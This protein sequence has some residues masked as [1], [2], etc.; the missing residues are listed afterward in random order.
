MYL[1]YLD[2]SGDTSNYQEQAHFVIA[3]VGIYEFR[4]D[5]LAKR[6]RETQR[7]YFPQINIP[8]VFHATD[9][10][11]GKG[12]FRTLTK[13]T[14]EKLLVD[15]YNII[16]EHRFPNVVVFGAVI[17]LED[18]RTPNKDRNSVFEE[19]VCGFNT[20][21]VENYRT[22]RASNRGFGNKGLIII[23]KNREEQY[24]QV[25]D[26]LQEGG[27]KY[28]YLGNVIDIPYFARCH[29]TPMLQLADLCSYAIFRYYEKKDDTYFKIVLPH[30]YKTLKGQLF[31]LKHLTDHP[32][33][34]VACVNQK[35]IVSPEYNIDENIFNDS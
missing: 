4:I 24:K 27:T 15:L 33:T 8:I 21:L 22:A 17:G 31:G 29:D 35:T 2:E 9:I 7:Q 25:L 28:G 10:H 18:A 20:F 14:R 5:I 13:E 19:V 32:C 12:I 6:L 16:N 11:A 26:N 23:D 34:C 3:G 1:L 30:I